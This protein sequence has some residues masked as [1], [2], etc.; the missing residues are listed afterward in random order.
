MEQEVQSPET[1]ETIVVWE[2][3]YQLTEEEWRVCY[4]R[5]RARAA[6]RVKTGVRLAL[7]GVLAAG[8]AA[9]YVF[10]EPNGMSLFLAILCVVLAAALLLV[11]W[12]ERRA[13]L[14]AVAAS[15]RKTR[16][17]EVEDGLEFGTADGYL[18]QPF[19][20]LRIETYDDMAIVCLPG[21]QR[22][23][24]P[25][26]AVDEAAWQ[27]LCARASDPSDRRS[28]TKRGDRI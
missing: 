24:V 28:R 19:S 8:F 4:Q 15:P 13:A 18:K 25:R 6:S 20:A 22:L 16:L 21:D 5:T 1:A 9:H 17:R 11:P 7:L 14:R 26:R 10:V 12:L 27:R 23:A 2:A 3:E